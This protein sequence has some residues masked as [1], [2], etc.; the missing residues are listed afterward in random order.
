MN[1]P[2]V[3]DLRRGKKPPVLL[4]LSRSRIVPDDTLRIASGIRFFPSRQYLDF[5]RQQKH[6]FPQFQ[7]PKPYARTR[8]LLS[9]AL[10][11]LF[12]GGIGTGAFAVTEHIVAKTEE[13]SV[14]F[15]EGT[16]LLFSQEYTASA[17]AFSDAQETLS[18]LRSPLF[19]GNTDLSLFPS[20]TFT[21]LFALAEQSAE[22]GE[23]FARLAPDARNIPSLLHE[24]KGDEVLAILQR[25]SEKTEEATTL[26]AQGETVLEEAQK[27][28]LLL[29]W[30][31]ELSALS[32]RLPE[33]EQSLSDFSVLLVAARD[34]LGEGQPHTTAVFFEN[35]GEI[36]A[37]GGFP[38]SLA[39]LT[40]NQG[41]LSSIFSDIYA[42]SWKLTEVLPSPPGFERLTDRLQLQDANYFFHFPLSAD[43]LRELLQKSDGPTAETI[44]VVTDD[45]FREILSETGPLPLPGTEEAL[46]AENASLLLSFFVE[47]KAFG[48]HTPKDGMAELFPQLLERVSALPP[49]KLF[50]LFQK[51]IHRK[52]ILVNS[53]VP[54]IQ[55]ASE[56][57]G[58]SGELPQENT[59]DFLAVVSA[60]VGGNKSDHFLQED[61]AL[62]SAIALSGSVQNT[63]TIHREHRWGAE[64]NELVDQLLQK[65][66]SFFVESELLRRILGAGDNHSYTQ[67]FVPLGSQ[68]EA[69]TGIPFEQVTTDV[70]AGKTVFS[71]RFPTVSAGNS[72]D[73]ILHYSLPYSLSFPEEFPLHFQ[74]QSGRDSVTFSRDIVAESGVQVSEFSPEKVLLTGDAR[75]S[76]SLSQ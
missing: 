22:L 39:I 59:G 57:L 48:Q 35:S 67:V 31:E 73:V 23:D 15:R 45:L 28:P 21:T 20:G 71:F 72:E 51:A 26:F 58:I 1:I 10:I 68:L 41:I 9:V 62:T 36:R 76:V 55:R 3:I 69:T 66:G 54:D 38:G 64:Q 32:T 14:S 7:K 63:L 13:V 11:A 33:T 70:Q 65:Y 43:M 12:F 19:L 27:N 46:T 5:P 40:G 4:T 34:L 24:G 53:T 29:P 37:T 25:I 52:W 75:F 6:V 50:S 49:E 44:I 8:T 18:A 56:Q 16:A 60:N 61:I 47:A 17:L 74:F 2:L 42:F 30:R